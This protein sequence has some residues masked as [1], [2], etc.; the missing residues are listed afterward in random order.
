LD[1]APCPTGG[2]YSSFPDPLA[3]FKGTYVLLRGRG[4]GK[5]G[6]GGQHRKGRGRRGKDRAHRGAFQVLA[7]GSRRRCYATAKQQMRKTRKVMIDLIINYE[8]KRLESNKVI[9]ESV[10]ICST[11]LVPIMAYHAVISH[12]YIGPTF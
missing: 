8:I 7:F 9:I 5:K 1:S 12:I 10:Q 11:S 4:R 3:A 6:G 2:A